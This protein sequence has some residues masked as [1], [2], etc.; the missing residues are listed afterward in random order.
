[1]NGVD[2]SSSSDHLWNTLAGPV[3]FG[4]SILLN[5]GANV[6]AP[7]INC[8]RIQLNERTIADPSTLRSVRHSFLTRTPVIYE[9]DPLMKP[10]DAGTDLREVWSVKPNI[11]LVAEAIWRLAT[12]NAVDSP[13]RVIPH[14]R[15]HAW[16]L[17]LARVK[18][19]S[20]M[21]T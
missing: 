21:P 2:S 11:D 20:S 19:G 13:I 4:R 7:W 3:V 18:M 8:N 10:P 6:P 14:G 9:V 16:R 12:L 1:M 5:L 15:S 17:T